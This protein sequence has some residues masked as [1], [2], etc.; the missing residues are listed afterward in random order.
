MKDSVLVSLFW[1]LLKCRCLSYFVLVHSKEALPVWW[2][3]TF[4][5][6]FLKNLPQFFSIELSP[7]SHILPCFN[8]WII[9]FYQSPTTHRHKIKEHHLVARSNFLFARR[10]KL[11]VRSF[12]PG[13]FM[14]QDPF[15]VQNTR[16][17]S[18]VDLQNHVIA[19]PAEPTYYESPRHRHQF[20]NTCSTGHAVHC[21]CSTCES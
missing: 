19:P 9:A 4:Y 21:R 16:G 12:V 17:G 5:H 13:A 8:M 20:G 11:T 3:I 6:H 15:Q 7:T 18:Y 14:P 1:K 2:T 10:L